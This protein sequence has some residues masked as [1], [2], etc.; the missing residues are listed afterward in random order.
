MA[1][2]VHGRKSTHRGRSP[3]QRVSPTHHRGRPPEPSEACVT[4]RHPPCGQA[5]RFLR[6]AFPSFR[7]MICFL[8]SPRA[9]AISPV[10]RPFRLPK[11]GFPRVTYP[12]RQRQCLDGRR[13]GIPK[14]FL[15]RHLGSAPGKDWGGAALLRLGLDTR[16]RTGYGRIARGNAAGALRPVRV[17]PHGGDHRA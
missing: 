12:T 14:A 9:W 7:A 8:F 13:I 10:E 5:A 16:G 6:A 11:G 15:R 4:T 1:S 3:Q 2:A 17:P